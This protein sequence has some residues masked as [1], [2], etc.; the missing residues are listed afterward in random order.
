MLPLGIITGRNEV[1]AKVMFLHVSVILF[2][3]GGVIR[4]GRNPPA[5]EEPPTPLAREEPPGPG[6]PPLARE[7]PPAT[8]QTPWQGGTPPGQGGTPLGPGRPPQPGRT[9]PRTRQSP[10]YGLRSAGTHPIG[11][12]SCFLNKIYITCDTQVK[13]NSTFYK[14]K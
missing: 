5:R 9:P 7:E 13:T 14:L 3:G 12:H 1:V 8:R 10:E 11:M 2:T 6:R 4:A